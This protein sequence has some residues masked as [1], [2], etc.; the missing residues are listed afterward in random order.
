MR[1]WCH[2]LFNERSVR[3]RFY[4][5]KSARFCGERFLCRT[6][7][8]KW[9]SN[10]FRRTKIML[11]PYDLIHSFTHPELSCTPLVA[12]YRC[13]REPYSKTTIR[14]KTVPIQ[15]LNYFIYFLF[16][17]SYIFNDSITFLPAF[18]SPFFLLIS[19]LHD[20]SNQIDDDCSCMRLFQSFIYSCICLTYFGFLSVCWLFF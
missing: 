19:A 13:V 12:R 10:G 15:L 20:T 2:S 6:L 17:I 18:L 5:T 16:A 14:H 3:F 1:K 11:W 4:G 8:L 9:V 7:I